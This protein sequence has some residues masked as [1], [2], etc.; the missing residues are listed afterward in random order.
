MYAR[1]VQSLPEGLD[2]LY[3]VK[4]DGYRCLAGRDTG[5]SE[6]LTVFPNQCPH[7]V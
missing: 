4:L 3:E 5:I 6:R 7:C 2:W 1:A